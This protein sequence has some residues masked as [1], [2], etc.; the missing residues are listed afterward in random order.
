MFLQAHAV[1]GMEYTSEPSVYYFIIWP[2]ILYHP[3]INPYRLIKLQMPWPAHFPTINPSGCDY[4]AWRIPD[5][6][7]I[8]RGFPAELLVS[9]FQRMF[10][11]GKLVRVSLSFVAKA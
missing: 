6:L 9:V 11:N 5:R 3:S 10:P 8:V 7:L 1:L 4:S 2:G